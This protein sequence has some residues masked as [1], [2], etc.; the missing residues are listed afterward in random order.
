ME[1]I[2]IEKPW[3]YEVLLGEWRGWRIKVLHITEG[4]R[5]SKQYHRE[6]VEYMFNLNDE[7]WTFIHPFKVH[8]PAA[9][10][11]DVTIIELSKGSDED[12]VRLADDYGRVDEDASAEF[13]MQEIYGLPTSKK[14]LVRS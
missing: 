13:E 7:T 1:H 11:D 14:M 6:K 9:Q 3:G 2:K 4:H 10:E 5:L 8:R 12:I